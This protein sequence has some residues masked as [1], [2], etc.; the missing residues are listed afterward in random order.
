MR[1]NKVRIADLIISAKDRKKKSG[2]PWGIGVSDIM[3][4]LAILLG[5]KQ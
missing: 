2:S 5:K 4:E 1:K 3:S